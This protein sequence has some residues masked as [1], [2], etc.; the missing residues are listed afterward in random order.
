MPFE[1]KLQA[2][3][4]DLAVWRSIASCPRDGTPFVVRTT[5]GT[6]HEARWEAPHGIVVHGGNPH[7][8]PV[9]EWRPL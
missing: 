4:F 8:A 7:L 9:H 6:E 3:P 1:H 5:D 2:V